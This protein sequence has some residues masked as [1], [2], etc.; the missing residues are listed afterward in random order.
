MTSNIDIRLTALFGI[1]LVSLL[2]CV[3]PLSAATIRLEAYVTLALTQSD[4]STALQL[5]IQWLRMAR[6]IL[7]TVLPATMF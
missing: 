3:A 2:V 6:T 7:P 4:E 1:I 5:R